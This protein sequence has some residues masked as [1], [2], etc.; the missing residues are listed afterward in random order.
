MILHLDMNSYFATVE[1]Q[2]NPFLRG[3]PV[4]VGGKSDNNRTVCA[5]AS[6]EAKKYGVKSGTS[7]WEAKK[8]CPHIQVVPADYTKYQ[9]ISRQVFSLLSEY[10]DKVE[11]FSID[12]AF[13]DLNHIE[14][15]T[16]AAVLAQEIKYRIKNQIGDYLKCSVGLSENKLLAKLASEKQKPDGLTI[17]KKDDIDVVLSTTPIEDLCGIG[18][19]L[20]YHLNQLG[21]TKV[22]ELGRYPLDNLIKLFGSHTGLHLQQM[23]QGIDPS[24]VLSYF[25]FPP[26][27]SFG[28]A[29]T[30]PVDISNIDDIKKVL[31]KLSEKVGRRLRKKGFSGQ[32]IHLYLRFNDFSGTGQ[33]VTTHFIQDGFDIYQTALTILSCQNLQKPIRLISVSISNLSSSQ[34]ISQT[35]FPRDKKAQQLL[36]ATDIINDHFG[37]FTVFRGVLT[38]I[39]DRIE[40]IPD[41]RSK[42]LM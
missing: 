21:I 22:G 29:Y 23:G 13:I 41:G 14:T 36:K 26:E 20:Q 31:L 37:E 16:E 5:A 7:V 27:K 3:K 28:H 38:H 2:C 30:L 10:S 39:K 19:R 40:N 33:Q 11:I 34:T 25:D 32:T 35:L 24:P 42:R 9:F 12:E 6:Y 8:L 18:R 15:Y 17:I 4:C 1:Q